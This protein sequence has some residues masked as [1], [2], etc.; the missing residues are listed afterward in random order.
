M[1]KGQ[2]IHFIGFKKSANVLETLEEK[3]KQH[4]YSLYKEI[5][6]L[7]RQRLNRER[8]KGELAFRLR[9]EAIARLGLKGVREHRLKQLEREEQLWR[10]RMACKVNFIPEL[11]P[12]C[13]VFV[14]GG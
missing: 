8:E 9:R 13:L 7:Y 4:G 12:V 6:Q 3:I 2:E 5:E 11:T 1:D 14:E 10:E